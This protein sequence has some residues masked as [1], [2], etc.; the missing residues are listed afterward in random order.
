M[1]QKQEHAFISSDQAPRRRAAKDSPRREIPMPKKSFFS[2]GAPVIQR[3]IY[4]YKSGRWDVCRDQF[5]P[6]IVDPNAEGV[7]GEEGQYYDGARGLYTHPD[8]VMAGAIARE[9]ERQEQRHDAGGEPRNHAEEYSY[10]SMNGHSGEDRIPVETP[11]GSALLGSSRARGPG[12]LHDERQP[13]VSMDGRTLSTR[14]TELSQV[15]DTMGAEERPAVLESM[16]PVF[17]SMEPTE[18]PELPTLTPLQRE[19]ATLVTTILIAENHMT[20]TPAGGK[21]QRAAIRRLQGG[22]S[23]SQVLNSESGEFVQSQVGGNRVMRQ[24]LA[25]PDSP[26]QRFEGM[27]RLLPSLSPSP[28]APDAGMPRPPSPEAPDAGMPELPQAA[29]PPSVLATPRLGSFGMPQPS[30]QALHFPMASPQPIHFHTDSPQPVHF[31]VPPPPTARLSPLPPTAPFSMSVPKS[32]V[33]EEQVQQSPVTYAEMLVVRF[34]ILIHVS[35][36]FHNEP[37]G[38]VS[39][40]YSRIEPMLD[41]PDDIAPDVLQSLEEVVSRH[42]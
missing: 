27:G 6:D 1:H 37:P 13:L 36:A 16:M 3:K 5:T 18:K 41:H 7:P 23:F 17:S 19:A 29:P 40:L 32:A 33:G 39:Y 28:E 42:R 38:L 25:S 30:P 8:A 4:I 20:R 10:V 22:A 15:L 26:P 14:Y 11:T 24:A 31:P 2:P 21:L 9:L 12:V 35:G 34:V